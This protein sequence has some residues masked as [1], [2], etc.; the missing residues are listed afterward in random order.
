MALLPVAA[1]IGSPGASV[2]DTGGGCHVSGSGS[3]WGAAA[4]EGPEA[5]GLAPLSPGERLRMPVSRL[6]PAIDR[7]WLPRTPGPWRSHRPKRSAGARLEAASRGS[8]RPGRDRL[9]TA[10]GGRGP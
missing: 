7:G 6:G 1:A 8:P 10:A 5:L 9:H 3:A 2:G 4:W